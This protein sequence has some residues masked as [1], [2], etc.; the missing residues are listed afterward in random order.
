[1]CWLWRKKLTKFAA[2]CKRLSS[3]TLRQLFLQWR[4]A[5]FLARDDVVTRTVGQGNMLACQCHSR[6]YVPVQ[7]VIDVEISREARARIFPFSPRA[8]YL[9]LAK[10]R[11]TTQAGSMLAQASQL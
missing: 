4:R 8:I 10:I 7:V 6:E 9:G 2:T 5:P 3:M 1:M 11:Q